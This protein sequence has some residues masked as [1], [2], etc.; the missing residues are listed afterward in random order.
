MDPTNTIDLI[1]PTTTVNNH[2]EKKKYV[3][4]DI[5][6]KKS[7]ENVIFGKIET[8][9]ENKI[10]SIKLHTVFYPSDYAKKWFK[11]NKER[12]G[13]D[14]HGLKAIHKYQKQTI[15]NLK[16]IESN[17]DNAIKQ[18]I[19]KDELITNINIH[20]KKIIQKLTS[21]TRHEYKFTLNKF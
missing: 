13:V 1:N 20:I 5:Y 16:P 2:I 9:F 18:N 3:L 19:N 21:R 7:S 11:N 15:I 10:T 17:F 12:L 8:Y 14:A 4:F 6:G